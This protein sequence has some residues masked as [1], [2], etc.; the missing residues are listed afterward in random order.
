MPYLEAATPVICNAAGQGQVNPA[1]VVAA[2]QQVTQA[3]TPQAVAIIN[4]ALAIY[5]AVYAYYGTNVQTSVVEPYLLGVCNGL[6]AVLPAPPS[7]NLKLN[8]PRL[9]PPHVR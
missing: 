7:S 2:L 8:A 3:K 1:E 9:L 4:G 6:R 5:E